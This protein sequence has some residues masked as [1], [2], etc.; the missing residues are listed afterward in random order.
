[1]SQFTKEQTDKYLKIICPVNL[2]AVA[3]KEFSDATKAWLLTQVK[4][5]IVDFAATTNVTKEFYQ[6]L[7]YLKTNLKKDQKLMYSLN[8]SSTLL[9]QIKE[10][11]IEQAL[12]PVKSIDEIFS[13]GK[14]AEKQTKTIDV[15]F[16]NPFLAATEKTLE[17]QCN[18]KVKLLKPY[19]KKE[20]MPNIAIA[21]VLSLI[22]N[23]FSGSV[24]LCFTQEVFLR[25]YENMFGEKHEK[26]TQELEDAAAELLNIIYGMAKIELNTK[27]YDFQKALPTVLTGEKIRIRQSGV[28]PAVIIPFETGFGQLHI[29]IEFNKPL[30]GKNV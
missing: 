22:S 6:V 9:R 23:G 8:L 28:E 2:D 15:D 14:T 19:L 18:T 4:H 10:D 16:I 25:V 5:F 3:A 30:E 20:Q 27:G 17:V 1:M 24:V 26:I 29:E 13:V 7:I 21:S 11:G 12:H